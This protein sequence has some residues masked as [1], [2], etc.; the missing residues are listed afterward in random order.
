MGQT[1]GAVTGALMVI[2]LKFGRT[3]V[4]DKEAKEKTYSLVQEFVTG[5]I[6]RNG[7]ISCRE[8]LGCDLS[9]QE[10]R[11]FAEEHK[12]IDSVCPKFVRDAAQ[13]VEQILQY[14]AIKEN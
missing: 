7:S 14:G 12:L 11:S 2:G 1:C 5:F 4:E 6:A 10:G 8:L 3:N 13:I 9:T